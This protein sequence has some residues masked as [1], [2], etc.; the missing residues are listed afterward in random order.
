MQGGW[1]GSIGSMEEMQAKALKRREAAAKRERAMAYALTHQ[2][3]FAFL[4]GTFAVLRSE[5]CTS[6]R[7]TRTCGVN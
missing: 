6:C 1:C 5:N 3:F 7:L 4:E 2:V